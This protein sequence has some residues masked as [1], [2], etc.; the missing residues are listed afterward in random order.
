MKTALLLVDI[1]KEY[2]P[3]GKV[4]LKGPEEASL[5]ARR[6]LDSFRE[7][8]RPVVFIQHMNTRAGAATFLPG[9]QGSEIHPNIQP[10][11]GECIIQKHFPNSFRETSLLEYLRGQAVEQLV[12]CGMMTHMCIDT[13]TRAAVDLGFPCLI[14]GDACAT[15]DLTYDG[16]TVPAEQVHA[17][18]LAALNGM[19]GKVL[20]TSEILAEI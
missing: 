16:Q 12:I 9:S 20:K 7:T 13:T 1:Q 2:F 14:A 5:N 3:G 19:F 18:F 8:G 6:L 15:R 4:P 17:A 10:Q 11:A